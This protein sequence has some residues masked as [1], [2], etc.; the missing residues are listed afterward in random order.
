MVLLAGEGEDLALPVKRD[1]DRQVRGG[2][3]SEEPEAAA[4]PDP[5]EKQRAISDHPGAE[6]RRGVR[7]RKARRQPIRPARR[8]RHALGVSAVAVAAG[9]RGASGRGSPGPL[10]HSAQTPHVE[11]IQPTPTASPDG[12][13]RARPVRRRRRGPRPDGRERRGAAPT[14][15]LRRCAGPS[16]T[17]RRPRSRS[18]PLPRTGTGAGRSADSSGD[19]STGAVRT[20]RM[21]R[22]EKLYSADERESARENAASEARHTVRASKRVDALLADY[23]EAHRTPGNVVCHTIGISLIVFG[24]L[25]MLSAVP[26]AGRLTAAEVAAGRGARRVPRPRPG[27]RRGDRGGGRSPR[28]SRASRL[29]LARRR[30]RLR[31]SAGSSRESATR[32]TRRTARPSCATSRT[33]SS[34]RR[35]SSTSSSGSGR[36]SGPRRARRAESAAVRPQRA[37][38]VAPRARHDLR[39]RVDVFLGRPEVDDAGA[40]HRPPAHHGVRRIDLPVL[41]QPLDEL[42]VQAIEVLLV[43]PLSGVR[44]GR[45]ERSETS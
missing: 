21:A 25:S 45:A 31:R 41:L 15:R 12:E 32:S 27:A 30:R 7:R 9:E 35:T 33:C 23:A 40:D 3:E 1:L 42:R 44:R 14:P 6:Q 26:I 8:R 36:S 24:V 28:S 4:G 11:A 39:H 2:A 20:R 37:V 16:G 13:V 43:A 17:R 38:E 19:R 10:R 5:R 22:T 18:R 29:G 34:G